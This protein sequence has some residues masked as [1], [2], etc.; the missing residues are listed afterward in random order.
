MVMG[1][2]TDGDCR[3]EKN[4]WIGTRRERVGDRPG[5]KSCSRM[6]LPP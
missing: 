1:E 5:G 3:L 6:L 4:V 2:K